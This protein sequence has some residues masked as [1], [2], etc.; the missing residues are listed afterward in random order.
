MEE[1]ERGHG[2]VALDEADEVAV[3]ARLH[4][5]GDRLRVLAPGVRALLAR[6]DRGLPARLVEEERERRRGRRG[7]RERPARLRERRLRGPGE[8]IPDRLL[9]AREVGHAGV[10][11][12][13]ALE[14]RVVRRARVRVRMERELVHDRPRPAARPVGGAE[15]V[16]E[17]HRRRGH[18]AA[19]VRVVVAARGESEPDDVDRRVDGLE[20]VVRQ[21][22]HLLVGRPGEPAP[23]RR[24][25]RPPEA[26][27]VR[28]V[29]D[30]ELLHLRV[31][32]REQR[33]VARERERAARRR[34]HVGRVARMDAE[35]DLHVVG[36]RNGQGA[37]EERLL[38]DL[39]RV[40]RV[41]EDGD[42]VL[43]HTEVGERGE[44]RRAAVVGVLAG[45][46]GDAETDGRVGPRGD[47]ERER[48]REQDAGDESVGHCR[49][50][51]TRD[52]LRTRDRFQRLRP[53]PVTP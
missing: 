25:L 10:R 8:G 2:R 48:K 18:V 52:P 20:R 16:D 23:A 33:R 42:S 14:Q 40:R 49:W 37:V 6:R 27:L 13:V 53:P 38:L 45:V 47:A 51:R 9:D 17:A 12:L 44:E 46:L 1:V 32:P 4:G 29:A 3:D 19:R 28:L 34:R 35:D 21:R 36:G 11:P 15:V 24:E 31:R 7:G 39:G 41:P 50:R 30:D 26:R 22:E 43:G 5:L